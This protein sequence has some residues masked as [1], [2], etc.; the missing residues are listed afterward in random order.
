VRGSLVSGCFS[1]PGLALGHPTRVGAHD[2][3]LTCIE[4]PLSHAGGFLASENE[5]VNIYCYRREVRVGRPSRA[6]FEGPTL[7]SVI[8]ARR[9]ATGMTRATLAAKAGLSSNTLMKVEQGQT[10]DPGVFKIAA[11]CRALSITVDELVRSAQ[12][13]QVPQEAPMTYGIV[14]AGYEGR[15]I[16]EYVA[17]LL[18]LGVG[19]VADVRLNAISRR[20][21][22]SKT[23][24]REA[25]ANAG[26]G[27]R[28]LRSLGNA[29]ENRQPFWTGR[30][31]EGRRVFRRA[32]QG[33]EAE[34]ELHEL[35][36]LAADHLVAVMC[37][38]ANAEMCHRQV[39]ID[40]VVDTRG[41]P[42]ATL[43]D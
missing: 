39:I 32:L 2:F 1:A 23:R 26:I 19:T 17:A 6:A 40:H 43:A 25:L 7:G 36:E 38:E 42:V 29:K 14:S 37:F 18:D 11:V 13:T 8:A 3:Q 35:A 33:P 16:E 31:E 30:V 21:G 12:R 4:G 41:V 10:S 22:F 27:Y 5:V 20:A 24:L 34:A 9:A 15:S 28:H